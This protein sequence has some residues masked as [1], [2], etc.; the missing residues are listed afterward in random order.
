MG[1][2][3]PSAAAVA[4]ATAGLAKLLHM[5]NAAICGVSKIV[6]SGKSPAAETAVCD[7]T[8]SSPGADP[9]EH[10]INAP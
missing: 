6:A 8:F 1:V 5:P 3:T 2:S 10:V 9:N 7:L 4:A